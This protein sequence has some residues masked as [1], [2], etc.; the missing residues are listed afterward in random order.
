[1]FKENAPNDLSKEKYEKPTLKAPA[2]EEK[3]ESE[4]ILQF[5][6]EECFTKCIVQLLLISYLNDMMENFYDSLTYA[7]IEIILKSLEKCF[8][9]AKEFNLE[10]NL[11]YKL[12]KDGFMADM[13]QLP[14]LIKQEREGLSSYLQ[15][16]FRLY[17]QPKEEMP[18]EEIVERIFQ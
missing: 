1:L 9:F 10:I 4:G 13:K 12:W 6:Q 5:N 15:I 16:L 8:M 18:Q 2:S 11:R 14:G 3:T 17:D 7:D